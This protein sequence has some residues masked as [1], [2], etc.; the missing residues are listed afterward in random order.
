MSLG[1]PH[2]STAFLDNYPNILVL[3]EKDLDD[4]DTIQSIDQDDTIK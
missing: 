3:V 1:D 4:Y 2:N